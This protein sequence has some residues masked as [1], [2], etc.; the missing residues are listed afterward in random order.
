MPRRKSNR[1]LSYFFLWEK[2]QRKKSL[3]RGNIKWYIFHTAK[4]TL[5][6]WICSGVIFNEPCHIHDF[7]EIWV[8]PLLCIALPIFHCSFCWLQCS[9]CNMRG[10]K[11]VRLFHMF[12]VHLIGLGFRYFGLGLVEA[13]SGGSRLGCW[14]HCQKYSIMALLCSIPNQSCLYFFF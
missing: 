14:K 7:L 1:L 12:D 3:H 4:G 13:F 10:K 11:T 9:W 5:G 6:C 8:K 2:R